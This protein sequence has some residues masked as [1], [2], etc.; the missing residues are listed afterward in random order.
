MAPTSR[1]LIQKEIVMRRLFMWCLASAFLAA[2]FATPSAQSTQSTISRSA[3]KANYDLAADWTAQKVGRLVFD[4]TI[5]PRWLETGDRFW[6]AY[7]TREGRK[8]YLVDPL[9]K[10][11]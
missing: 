8:F 5:A 6:Y 9:K 2:A 10:A 4:T 1:T 7:Q 11:K 3:P